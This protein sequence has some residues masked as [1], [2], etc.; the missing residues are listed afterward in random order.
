M[1]IINLN[2][3]QLLNC[4]ILLFVALTACLCYVNFGTGKSS[5]IKLQSVPRRLNIILNVRDI[6]SSIRHK[7]H[8]SLGPL[9][10]KEFHLSYSC[11]SLFTDKNESITWP[12]P[13]WE[14]VTDEVKNQF[15][16]DGETLPI[17]AELVESD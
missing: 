4:A 15:T 3:K 11:H 16:L 14:N 12:P 6:Y 7:E 10:R 9:L 5:T 2:A 8:V 13:L 17:F 1:Q